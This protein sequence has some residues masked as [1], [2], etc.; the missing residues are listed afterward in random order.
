MTAMIVLRDDAWQVKIGL[1]DLTRPLLFQH[2]FPVFH[3]PSVYRWQ[4]VFV[5]LAVLGLSVRV[6]AMSVGFALILAFVLATDVSID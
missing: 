1:E 3:F 2:P 4:L 6:R 5:L